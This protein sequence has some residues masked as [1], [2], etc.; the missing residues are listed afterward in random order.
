MTERFIAKLSDYLRQMSHAE[1]WERE[2]V[3]KLKRGGLRV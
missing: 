1:R 2:M 3:E